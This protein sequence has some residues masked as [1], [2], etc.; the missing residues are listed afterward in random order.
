M[1]IELENKRTLVVGAGMSGK[2]AVKLLVAK[3][4][5]VTVTDKK[6]LPRPSPDEL[7]G[8]FQWRCGDQETVMEENW[9]FIVISPGVPPNLPALV[10]A[11]DRGSVIIGEIELGYNFISHKIV[12]I[13]GTKGKST[14]T[15]LVGDMLKASGMR[16][17]VGGNIGLPLCELAL[18]PA[19]YDIAVLELSSFQLETL[20]NFRAEVAVL[21]NIAPDHLDRYP[22]MESYAAAKGELFRRITESGA[23]VIPEEGKYL[24]RIL[25]EAPKR[26]FTFGRE[27]KGQRCAFRIG[28]DSFTMRIDAEPFNYSVGSPSLGGNYNMENAMSAALAARLCGASP[29]AIQQT[30][31]NFVGLSHRRQFVMEFGEVQFY[32]DSKATNVF[33]A[34]S[35]LRSFPAQR[36]I[37][38]I[39]GGMLKEK[40]LSELTE[41]AKGRVKRALCIGR[42]GGQIFAALKNIVAS[43]EAGNME[44]AVKRAFEVADAG[45]IVLLSPATA[46]FDAYNNYAERGEHFSRLVRERGRPVTA[47]LSVVKKERREDER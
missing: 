13:T 10:G 44:N 7:K 24:D 12:A 6:P 2:S 42:D 22:D 28:S 29:E 32:N 45:D 1:K 25:K 38:L 21:L 11:R 46:S 31:N 20:V 39:V 3:G 37:I 43:E 8:E 16:P 34:A 33:S 9:D 19:A 14:T 26:R 5:Q 41:A 47:K 30:L 27:D 23:I 15:K 36:N 4:A 35:T 40:E 18:S 17:F